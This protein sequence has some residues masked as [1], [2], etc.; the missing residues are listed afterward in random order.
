MGVIN[1][2]D[3]FDVRKII[4]VWS[5]ENEFLLYSLVLLFLILWISDNIQDETHNI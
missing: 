5:T 1:V 2:L 4:N 3:V